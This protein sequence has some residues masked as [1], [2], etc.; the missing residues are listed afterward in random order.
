MGAT[1]DTYAQD[2]NEIAKTLKQFMARVPDVDTEDLADQLDAIVDKYVLLGRVEQDTL[3][4]FDS[5]PMIDRLVE[6]GKKDMPGATMYGVPMTEMSAEQ[7]LGV[8][9]WL[10]DNP[11]MLSYY[12]AN[13]NV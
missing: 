3:A 10:I 11:E 13:K 6:K 7:L 1:V 5:K 2:I 12:K 8:I 9:A 4:K